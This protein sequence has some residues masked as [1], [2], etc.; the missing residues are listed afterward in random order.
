MSD[1]LGHVPNVPD[2][3]AP[4]SPGDEVGDRAPGFDLHLL[5]G[6]AQRLFQV[7]RRIG[8]VVEPLRPIRDAQELP[9][10]PSVVCPATED[11]AAEQDAIVGEDLGDVGERRGFA[12]HRTGE[13]VHHE[14]EGGGVEMTLDGQWLED[15]SLNCLGIETR[16]SFTCV[17]EDVRVRIEQGDLRPVRHDLVQEVPGTGA[18]VEVPVAEVLSVALQGWL[19]GRPPDTRR[20]EPDHEPVVDREEPGRVVLLAGIG[21]VRGV[22]DRIVAVDR[23]GTVTVLDFNRTRSSTVPAMALDLERLG[24]TLTIDITTTG[25]RTG[26]PSRI[27][28]WWFRI[29]DRFVITGTPG[30]RDWYANVLADPSMT[31]HLDGVD[32]PARA[33]I[34]TDPVFRRTVMTHPRTSWYTS[35]A[36]LDALVET[37]PM[38]EVILEPPG[39]SST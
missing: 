11:G 14:A 35:E 12:I 31:V 32:L 20:H 23:D 37:A 34:V 24:R 16:E 39:R 30:P 13:T 21:R 38:I 10:G 28:I 29:D 19:D 22:H 2:L 1:D 17:G 25:R 15:V 7:R 9:S 3:S 36:D 6:T 26:R 4:P 5:E 18:D 8:E 33:E 27:E